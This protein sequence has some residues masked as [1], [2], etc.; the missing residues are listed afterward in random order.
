[1]ENGEKKEKSGKEGVKR[2][3][4]NDLTLGGKERQME[5]G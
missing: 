2:K 1:M 3:D 5:E 4:Y